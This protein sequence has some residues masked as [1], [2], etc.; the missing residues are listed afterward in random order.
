MKT[1]LKTNDQS[2]TIIKPQHLMND[3]TERNICG[4]RI[5]EKN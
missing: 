5:V 3:M 1:P 4:I 2:K